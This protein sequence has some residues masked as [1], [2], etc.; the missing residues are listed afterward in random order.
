MNGR[1]GLLMGCCW[2]LGQEGVVDVS[3]NPDGDPAGSVVD[4]RDVCVPDVF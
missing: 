1:V 4:F 2:L 3:G